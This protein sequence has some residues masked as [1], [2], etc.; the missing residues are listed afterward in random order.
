LKIS[1]VRKYRGNIQFQ[2]INSFVPT[3]EANKTEEKQ[4]NHE[5]NKVKEQRKIES[6]NS[7]N[8]SGS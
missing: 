8:T 3:E 4:K 2:K 5:G 1:P 6:I 7:P